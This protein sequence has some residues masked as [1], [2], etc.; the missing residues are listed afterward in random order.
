VISKADEYRLKATECDQ[1]AA[2]AADA[3]IKE[4]FEDLARQWRVMAKQAERLF[5]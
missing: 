4:Q 3:D 5:R 1:R 2:G